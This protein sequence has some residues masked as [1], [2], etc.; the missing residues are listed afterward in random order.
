M[1]TDGWAPTAVPQKSICTGVHYTGV[2]TSTYLSIESSEVSVI[3]SGGWLPAE[4]SDTPFSQDH[5]QLIMRGEDLIHQ[6]GLAVL[7]CASVHRLR[8]IEKYMDRWYMHAC[9]LG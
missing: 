3:V 7:L 4:F 8:A 1:G 2:Y 5:H 9:T 6:S